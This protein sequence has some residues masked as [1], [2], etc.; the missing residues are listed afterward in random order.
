MIERPRITYTRYFLWPFVLWVVLGGLAL[1]FFN[2]E[3]LFSLF[4]IH[5]SS[6]GDEFMYYMSMLGE[7][8]FSALVLMMMLGLRKL[9]NWWYFTAAM[10]TNALSALLTQ[11]VKS[12]VN[13]P[14][15]L[16]YFH[17][18]AWVHILP[19][20]PRL[21]SRSFPSGHTCAAFALCSFVSFLLPPKHRGWS[22]L[23]FVVALLI[24]YSRMYL[25]AHFFL[26]VYVGSILGTLFTMAMLA[27]MVFITDKYFKKEEV[28]LEENA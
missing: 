28:V 13:A 2:K 6:F 23:L 11:G 18:A 9:R 4:N 27:L 7:G 20:W 15:P 8:P 10:L 16:N 26:D 12:L 14:R 21:Y 5:H 24:G 3:Q 1:V 19:D 25:A 22:V 17:D